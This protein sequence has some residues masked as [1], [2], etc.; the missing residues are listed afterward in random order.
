M[1]KKLK[2]SVLF[3]KTDLLNLF[4]NWSIINNFLFSI[5]F[6]AVDLNTFFGLWG[7]FAFQIYD[8]NLYRKK[9][10]SFAIFIHFYC[11]DFFP[12]QK[13]KAFKQKCNDVLTKIITHFVKAS[14]NETLTHTENTW[15]FISTCTHDIWIC[16]WVGNGQ[17][18]YHFDVQR[19]S[20]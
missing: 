2:N 13:S 20:R 17:W 8:A 14:I 18:P 16:P 9:H 12:S 19:F 6:F 15:K 4:L 5:H 11:G 7:T 3:L 10:V 1:R